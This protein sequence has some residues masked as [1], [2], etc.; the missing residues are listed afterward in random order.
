FKKVT[1]TNMDFAVGTPG[2]ICPEQ[3][4]G[5]PVDHRGDRYSVGVLAYELL[6]GR[7]PFT[8]PTGM[9]MVLAHATEVPPGFSELGLEGAIPPQVEEVVQACLAKNPADRPQTAG[10]LAERFDLAI[11]RAGESRTATLDPDFEIPD[12]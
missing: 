8:G 10:E 7:L 6:T 11:L 9:D 4:R 5:D 12:L 3:V 2:Y 1:D